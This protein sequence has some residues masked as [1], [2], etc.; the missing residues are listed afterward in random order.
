MDE[1]KQYLKMKS[2]I[3]K[4]DFGQAYKTGYSKKELKL[5]LSEA[6]LLLRQFI[7]HFRSLKGKYP[8]EKRDKEL[9]VYLILNELFHSLYDAVQAL[10][11][12]NIRPASRVFR[13]VM[14]CRDIIKLVYSENGEKYVDKWFKDEFIAHRDFRNTL[15]KELEE[16]T[17]GVYQLYSKHTHRSYSVIMDSY[18]LVD[19]G[20]QFNIYFDL[21]DATHRKTLSKYCVHVAQFILNVGLDPLEYDLISEINMSLIVNNMME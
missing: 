11:H 3:W 8:M 1:P 7:N 21:E 15:S 13:E 16:M 14:E 18:T 5:F 12:G 4:T 17:R 10:E 20:L 19:K 6:E 9:L 2:N